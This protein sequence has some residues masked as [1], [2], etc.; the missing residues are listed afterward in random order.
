MRKKR[1]LPGLK[2]DAWELLSEWIRRK[3][4]DEGGTV[5]CYTC[6]KLLHWKEAH[7]AHFVGGRTGSVLLDPRILRVGCYR[8][9]VLLHGNYHQFTLKMIDEVGREKT[10]EY[11]SLKNQTKK[12]DRSD[13]EGFIKEYKQRL[14]GL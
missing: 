13:L 11:L 9:N 8:C 14:E 5:A 1:S 12:W 2:K 10:E 3:D 4:A 7:A 6:G